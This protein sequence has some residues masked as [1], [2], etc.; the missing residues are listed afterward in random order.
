MINSTAKGD[1][2]IPPGYVGSMGYEGFLVIIHTEYVES[3]AAYGFQKLSV[4]LL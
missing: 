2:E 3:M 1:H 4:R